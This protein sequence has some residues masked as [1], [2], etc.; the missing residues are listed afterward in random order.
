MPIPW[1]VVVESEKV[2]IVPTANFSAS[3]EAAVDKYA[4]LAE[5]E[6]EIS[7]CAE[8]EKAAAIADNANVSFF[9]IIFPFL[10]IIVLVLIKTL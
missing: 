2:A 3:V 9:I 8:A 5:P 1:S 10:I 6:T 4:T 7:A